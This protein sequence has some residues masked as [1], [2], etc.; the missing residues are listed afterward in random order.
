[1]V[2]ILGGLRLA[3]LV[4]QRPDFAERLGRRVGRLVGRLWPRTRPETVASA[5]RRLSG[6]AKGILAAPA[7]LRA[8]APAVAQLVADTGSLYLFFLA[9]GY[10]PQPGAILVAPGPPT[11]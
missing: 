10:R 3:L 5:A 2:F 1:M 8:S 4:A 6:R 9:T 11:L 7:F